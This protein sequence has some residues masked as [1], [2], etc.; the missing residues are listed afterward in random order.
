MEK[1]IPLFEVNGQVPLVPHFELGRAILAM[2][3]HWR[4]VVGYPPQ[5]GF[6]DG[7]EALE[8]ATGNGA[9]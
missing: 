7:V 2:T 3:A 8:D 4:G 6:P 9:R 5:D 1:H